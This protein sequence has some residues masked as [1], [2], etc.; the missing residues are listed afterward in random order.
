MTTR[1]KVG[2]ALVLLAC[3]AYAFF[4]YAADDIAPALLDSPMPGMLIVPTLVVGIWL[5]LTGGSRDQSLSR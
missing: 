4:A 1:R 2:L 3:L 5:F